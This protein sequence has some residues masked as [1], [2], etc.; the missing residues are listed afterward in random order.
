MSVSQK[1]ILTIISEPSCTKITSLTN[2]PRGELIAWIV[3]N[4][5]TEAPFTVYVIYNI[6]SI[7]FKEYIYK[8]MIGFGI[9]HHY[10]TCSYFIYNKEMPEEDSVHSETTEQMMNKLHSDDSHV[11]VKQ[12]SFLTRH[13]SK[14]RYPLS[15]CKS[16]LSLSVNA[17]NQGTSNTSDK[18]H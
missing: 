12:D 17:K 1:Y 10:K 4:L 9:S 16:L 2:K 7:N 18:G 14:Y 11:E 13:D 3:Y 8:I 15:G 6:D 5:M